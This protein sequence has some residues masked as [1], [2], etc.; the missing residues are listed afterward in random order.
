M[1]QR[2][3]SRHFQIFTTV[4]H[5]PGLTEAAFKLGLSKPAISKVLRLMERETGVTL[6]RLERGRL[7]PTEAARRLLPRAEQLA[8]HAEWALEAAYSLHEDASQTVVVAAH[9]PPLIAILPDAIE[10]FGH[11]HPKVNVRLRIEEPAKVL[12]LVS[13]HEVDLGVTSTPAPDAA[14]GIDL[15][16]RRTLSEDLLVVAM[17]RRHP[18]VAKQVVRPEDLESSTVLALLEVSPTSILVRAALQEA[19][20]PIPKRIVAS[21]S[22]G[23]CA[24]IQ[25]NVGVGLINPLLLSTGIFPDLVTRPFRPRITLRTEIF[26]SSIRP[27]TPSARALAE[28]I[29]TAAATV[30]GE[31]SPVRTAPR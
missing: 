5:S 12:E 7:V 3:H 13:H 17:H 15:C 16:E 11:R 29:E 2:L 31:A 4:M 21:T 10:H 14:S 22:L 20:I 30:R 8:K 26:H 1:S 19:G 25:Q 6:F 18:L 23:V 27:L 28:A 24:L 9:A